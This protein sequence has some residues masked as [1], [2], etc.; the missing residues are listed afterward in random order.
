VEVKRRVNLPNKEELKEMSML[1][2][3]LSKRLKLSLKKVY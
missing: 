2:E 1:G 3:P